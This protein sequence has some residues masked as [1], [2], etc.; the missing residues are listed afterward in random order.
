MEARENEWLL[1]VENDVL[2]TAFCYAR[3]TMA[4]EELTI[5]GRE[6]SLTAPSSASKYFK[7]LGDENHEFIYTYTDFFMR[8]FVRQSIELA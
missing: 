7:S 5:F 3:Y 4:M 2:S 1:F 6:N 8:K